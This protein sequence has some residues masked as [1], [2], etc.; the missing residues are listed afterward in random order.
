[1]NKQALIALSGGVDSAVCVHLMQKEGY[2]VQAVV[3]EFSPAHQA[4]VRAAREVAGHLNIPLHVVQCMDLFREA[5]I[6]P[7]ADHYKNGRTPNP[8]IVCNPLVKFRMLLETADKLGIHTVVTGHYAH[9]EREGQRWMLKKAAYLPRD[10]SYMLYRLTQGQLS[11]L[12]LPLSRYSKDDVRDI[13]RRASLPCSESPDSQEICFI[14]QGDYP[15]YIGENFGPGKK[16]WFVSPDGQLLQEH[17]GIEFYTV[18]QR[19]HLGVSIGVPV[20]IKKIDPESGNIFLSY[21]DD[22]F[23][24]SLELTDCVYIPFDT[25][26]SATDFNVK[27]RS[28]AFPVLANVTP[29]PNRRARV[30]FQLPV[31]APAPGQ[32]CVFYE[33]TSVIGGGFIESAI[34]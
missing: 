15:Q 34:G 14:P 24:R 32:S 1:M 28:Q 12:V 26:G 9:V 16:G 8:C 25:L 30:T 5:V 2:Q 20:C 10:Q 3:L 27:I 17:K 21:R 22:V 13:A 19:K 6:A 33:G 31:R 18:G 11:R 23:F 7:F 4:A 29:L